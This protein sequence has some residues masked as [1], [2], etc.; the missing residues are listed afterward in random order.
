MS[1]SDG[2]RFR[3]LCVDDNPSFLR[4]LKMGLET[5]GFEVVPAFDGP[6]ALMH[7]KTY[8]GNLRAIVTDHDMPQMNGLELVQLVRGMAFKG[9]IFVMSGR[10]GVTDLRSYYD[11]AITGFL[12]K[13]F[14]LSLIAA[15]LLQ[16]LG[17]L[18]GT[19][20]DAPFASKPKA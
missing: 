7:Y 19:N 18:K 9:P 14:E 5:Y 15:M 12:H 1:S 13:P 17:P 6:N 20:L 16:D 4:M 8:S 11:H 10:L 2:S 3:I